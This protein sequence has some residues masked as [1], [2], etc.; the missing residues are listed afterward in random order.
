MNI[1]RQLATIRRISSI[2]PIPN[3]DAIELARVD[4]WQ[5]VVKK[6]EYHPNDLAIYCEIDSWIP[7]ELAPFL[8]KGKEPREFKGIQGER[9][10][11]IKLRGA[12]SQG[13]LLPLDKDFES[14]VVG[15]C[16]GYFRY[17]EEGDSVDD[18]YG[19]IKY[20]KELP[21]NL[22]GK[23]KG[24]FP[25]FIPRTDQNRIQNVWPIF[26]D[27]LD[28]FEVSE[29]LDGS[30]ITI[31]HK[32]GLV[33]VCSRNLDLKDE[34][35]NTFWSAAKAM[36]VPDKLITFNRNIA[37]QGEL[38]GPGIQ[39]NPYSLGAHQ[40]RFFDIWDI[41]KQEYMS[42]HMR[43]LTL[44]QLGYSMCE[45]PILGYFN[46]PKTLEELLVAAESP[47]ILNPIAEREGLVYKST[48]NPMRSFKVISNKWLLNEK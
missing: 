6:G 5:V 32:D 1:D 3:A 14:P 9:L 30:S 34:G 43:L 31:Y 26:K 24:N 22:R 15:R 38:I 21:A 45:A 17:V 18:F 4:G 2:E 19:I 42:S 37:L 25:D 27:A 48:S 40:I 29:K 46:L 10:R 33:G 28:T 13:L 11:T 47:S 41:D 7:Y 12:L 36:L 39:G 23:A 16:D 35:E 8:S 44:A 20:E